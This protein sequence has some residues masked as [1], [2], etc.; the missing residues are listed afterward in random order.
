MVTSLAVPRIVAVSGVRWNLVIWSRARFY[1]KS[2]YWRLVLVQE[3]L[4]ER[5]ISL[6]QS[7]SV[8]LG[9][10]QCAGFFPNWMSDTSIWTNK[11]GTSQNRREGIEVHS[12]GSTQNFR[13]VFVLFSFF[14]STIFSYRTVRYMHIKCTMYDTCGKRKIRDI[15]NEISIEHRTS[16]L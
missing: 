4:H 15:P 2:I 11:Q 13:T 8:V 3:T 7:L 5:Q 1:L 10:E 6:R 14:F 12:V 16:S 9:C